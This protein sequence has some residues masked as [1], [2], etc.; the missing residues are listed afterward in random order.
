M[1]T[2]TTDAAAA[3]R[4]AISAAAVPESAGLRISTVPHSENGTGPAISLELVSE[5]GADDEIIEA[6]GAQVFLA[7][8]MAASMDDKLLDAEI[9]A[10]GEV[11]FALREQ[12]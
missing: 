12:A 10:G 5:P 3:I 7:P 8:G 4:A 6:D 11:R 9:E 2:L 1:L